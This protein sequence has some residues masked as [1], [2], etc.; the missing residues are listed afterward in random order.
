MKLEFSRKVFEKYSN[1]KFDDIAHSGSRIVP[2]GCK[3]TQ[4]DGRT[5]MTKLIVALR[6]FANAPEERKLRLAKGVKSG[7]VVRQAMSF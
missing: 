2:R 5:D 7:E 1:V 3:D 6:N 4:T